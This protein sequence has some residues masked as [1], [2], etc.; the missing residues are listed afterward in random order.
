MHHVS[1]STGSFN[2]PP[3]HDRYVAGRGR[4]ARLP[5]LVELVKAAQ[6]FGLH[7]YFAAGIGLEFDEL[8]VQLTQWPPAELGRRDERRSVVR[9][10]G[11]RGDRRHH[12][13]E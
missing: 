1:G 3:D 11:M 12:E 2:D 4:E 8:A 7:D 13:P 5:R 6:E 9:V 10:Q